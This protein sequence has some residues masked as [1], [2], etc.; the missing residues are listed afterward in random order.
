MQKYSLYFIWYREHD[1]RETLK[2]A[3]A[4]TLECNRF[5]SLSHMFTQVYIRV[6]LMGPGRTKCSREA[7]PP[8]FQV[9]HPPSPLSQSPTQGLLMWRWE[10]N[11]LLLEWYHQVKGQKGLA[12]PLSQT[13]QCLNSAKFRLL[14]AL[15]PPSLCGS[16][17]ILST[18]LFCLFV[19]LFVLF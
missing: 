7:C 2:K 3:T 18:W 17:L 4:I 1:D 8:A 12:W 15:P 9:P 11:A 13:N 10:G 19:C 6:L 5:L 14:E 16:T